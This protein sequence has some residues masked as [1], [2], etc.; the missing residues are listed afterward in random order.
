MLLTYR[1]KNYLYLS[2]ELF[3]ERANRN[4]FLTKGKGGKRSQKNLSLSVPFNG[5]F[6]IFCYLVQYFHNEVLVV[7]QS[8]HQKCAS[9]H[10]WRYITTRV[11]QSKLP[12]CWCGGIRVAR[13]G[14]GWD[15]GGGRF[16]RGFGRVRTQKTG[17]PADRVWKNSH[18]R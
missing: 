13:R 16:W 12:V 3:R 10:F 11:I 9:C 8:D 5:K 15:G 4:L 7:L 1:Y 2:T 6:S 18:C 17:R 14:G